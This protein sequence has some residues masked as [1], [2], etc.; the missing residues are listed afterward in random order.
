MPSG[1]TWI[2]LGDV[3]R[4]RPRR[5][6]GGLDRPALARG[7]GRRGVR[8][9]RPGERHRDPD[10]DPDRDPRQHARARHGAL[11]PDL[12]RRAGGRRARRRLRHRRAS[13][14]ARRWWSA[15][16]WWSRC[17]C[18]PMRGRER[19]AASLEARNPDARVLRRCYFLSSVGSGRVP[20]GRTHAAGDQH[21][22]TPS[23]RSPRPRPNRWSAARRGFSS[24]ARKSCVADARDRAAPIR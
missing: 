21:P 9:L 3:A 19:I 10:A 12:P 23:C 8:L 14:C 4:R 18:G 7:A 24:S 1:L 20:S 2:V 13:G 15:R 16:C 17:G 11:R 22:P 5:H 6:H